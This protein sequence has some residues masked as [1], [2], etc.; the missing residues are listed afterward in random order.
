[1]R[2]ATCRSHRPGLKVAAAAALVASLAV[3]GAFVDTVPAAPAGGPFEGPPTFKA[4]EILAPDLV[5]GPQHRVEEQ[6][7][8]DGYFNVY[9]IATPEFG[10]FEAVS[11][12][13]LGIRVTEI[14]ALAKLKD[15]NEAAILAGGAV[16]AFGDLFTGAAK[17]VTSPVE[18][19]KGIP[20]GV[21]RLF[22]FAGRTVTRV[23][24]KIDAGKQASSGGQAPSR[25]ETVARGT[26][27][28]TRAILGVNAAQRRWAQTLGVDP[29]TSN[30]VLAKAIDRAAK[31]EAAGRFSTNLVPGGAVMT[32]VSA[33]SNVH[34]LV[35]KDW[36]EVDRLN[37]QRLTAMGV[38]SS[39]SRA[40]RL[41]RAYSL[42]RQT[43]LIAA[44]DSLKGLPGRSGFVER[45][46][47]VTS[48]IHAQFFQEAAELMEIFHRRQTALVRLLPEAG[49]AGAL[50]KGNRVV[51]L[52]PVDYMVWTEDLATHA[53]RITN[54]AR[55]LSPASREV[56]LTGQVSDRARDELRGRGWTVRERSLQLDPRWP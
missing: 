2:R 5:Q 44:L 24:E 22:G 29:Y 32:A 52:L 42:T 9:R 53:D 39:V 25:G 56:W 47:R 49:G 4:Q 46:A 16:D 51:Q 41:N 23:G 20:E 31:L 45:A 27:S 18:T 48:E 37:E 14:G 34:D 43:R 3:P 19:V 6:V 28:A 21:N 33:A 54:Q 10:V 7:R 13:M 38:S 30:E 40:F 12:R 11:T 50:A 35:Y 15:A 8:N 36:D 17:V 26:E 55:T 1:M